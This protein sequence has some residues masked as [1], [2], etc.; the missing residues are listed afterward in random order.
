VLDAGSHKAT[1]VGNAAVPAR[2]TATR[3]RSPPGRALRFGSLSV[4]FVEPADVIQLGCRTRC[5]EGD[6]VDDK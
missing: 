6:D 2:G 3:W 5:R 4:T 1:F